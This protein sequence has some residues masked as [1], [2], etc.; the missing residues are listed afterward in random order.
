MIK[1]IIILYLSVVVLFASD[2]RY[3]KYEHVKNFIE[4]LAQ[5]SIELGLKYNVPPSAILAIASVESGYGR[6]YVASISGNILSLGTNKGEKEL[7]PLFLP[8]IREPY[9]IIYNPKEIAKYKKSELRYKKRAKSL[10]KD[11]RPTPYAGTTK[12]LEYFD[13]NKEDKIK[14]NLICID[15]FC[16]VWISESY[17]YEPFKKARRDLDK[18]VSL[19]GKDVLFT[20]IVSEELINNIGGKPHSFNYRKTW[21]K[22]VITVMKNIG[23]VELLKDM[24]NGKSFNDAWKRG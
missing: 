22:K 21:P 4:P 20:K 16:R 14:A 23:L 7:P 19:A 6:G 13:N 10:K 17:R 11:Y 2:Y 24:R 15:D 8:N 3:R 9:K 12:M 1:Y 18:R 5:K